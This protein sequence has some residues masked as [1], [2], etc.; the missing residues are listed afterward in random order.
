MVHVPEGVQII[1]SYPFSVK[2]LTVDVLGKPTNWK[3]VL[4]NLQN[5][6]SYEKLATRVH[7]LGGRQIV[8]PT[9]VHKTDISRSKDLRVFSVSRDQIAIYRG[10]E[11]DGAEIDPSEV[12]ALAS[13]DCPTVAIS[14]PRTKTV[15]AMHFNRENGVDNDILENALLRFPSEFR[16]EML[17]TISA[18]ISAD[19]FDHDWSHPSYGQSNRRRTEKLIAKYGHK[20][21]GERHELGQINLRWVA[22][23]KLIEAGIPKANIYVDLID[24]YTD[25]M[26]WSHRASQNRE[27]AKW[28][29]GGRNMVLVGNINSGRLI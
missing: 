4:K 12:Y 3:E 14:H 26:F 17:A 28:G 20:A 7:K 15:V 18:G 22:A 10:A 27:S 1:D 2:N 8:C 23:M 21:A 19:H 16:H 6:D 13:G 25:E 9:P 29:E 11:A 24:T 5:D